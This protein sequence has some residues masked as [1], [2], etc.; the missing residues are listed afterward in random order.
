MDDL[1][2]RIDRALGGHSRRVAD[3]ER[4]QAELLDRLCALE[5]LLDEHTGG[6]WARRS[7]RQRI[8]GR[9]CPMPIRDSIRH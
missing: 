9:D 3:L 5:E 4:G 7:P 6:E 2:R 8:P 1:D